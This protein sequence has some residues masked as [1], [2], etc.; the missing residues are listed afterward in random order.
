MGLGKKLR[1]VGRRFDKNVLQKAKNAALGPL[2]KKLDNDSRREYEA[3]MTRLQ[4]EKEEKRRQ[5]D[6]AHRELMA[7][8]EAKNKE[9]EGQQEWT[10]I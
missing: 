4:M 9:N 5:Q 10:S 7:K 8:M 3:E 6:Q 2:I 1:K